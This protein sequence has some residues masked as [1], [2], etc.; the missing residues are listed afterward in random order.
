MGKVGAKP[1]HPYL[2]YGTKVRPIQ[3][4]SADS[5]I[6]AAH[7]MAG[8][9]GDERPFHVS[10]VFSEANDFLGSGDPIDWNLS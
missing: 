9:P 3:N 5:F 10:R 8:Y 4:V 7:P 1:F 2:K 6:R